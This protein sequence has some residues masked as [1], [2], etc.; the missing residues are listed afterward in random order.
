MSVSSIGAQS[1]LIMQQLV[2]MRSQFDDLQRQLGTG[3]KSATYAGLGINRGV[4]VS[5]NA[6]LSA[7][8]GYDNTIDNVMARIN[9]MNT[10]LGNMIDI[11]TTVKSAMVQANGVSN[12]SGALVAQQTG[13]SS[14]DQLLALLNA[15]AGDRYLFSGR[16]T[17]TPAVETLDHIMNGDGARAGLKQLIFERNQADLGI[18]GLGRLTIGG[19]GNSVQVDEQTTS[20][21]L[22]L[23][24]ITSTVTG[25]TVSGPTGS[26]A[27]ESIDFSAAAPNPGETVTLRFNLPD[28]TSENL[29]LT[30][31]TDSPPGSNEFTIGT[32]PG[33]TASSF[34]TALSTAVGKL[35]GTSLTAASAIAAS[36]DFFNADANNPPQ[37]VGGSSPFYAATGM[38][39]G[40][41]A[42]TVIWYTG[43][44]GT[45]PARS[46]ATAKI[47][48]SLSV[49]Y[50]A[51][52]NEDALR[53]LVQN[54]ATL[55]AV[56]ISPTDP[57]G[58]GLSS[59][60]DQRLTAN[61]GAPGTQTVTDIES[62][63]ASAQTSL[64]AAK[65]RHQQANSTLNDFL[66]QIE[67]VSNEDVG[68]QLL[69]LQTRMQAS[70]QVTSMLSQLSLVNFL[71]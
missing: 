24:S 50:G 16:A 52:A 40:T 27:S 68:A 29:T 66:Q 14:L 59:E 56:T 64:K 5:L 3:Q 43:E 67:G 63:L 60:L 25:A 39:A 38:V 58:V 44:T 22:K 71:K 26:P 20:F 70:M 54:V 69:T 62:D 8:S 23:A 45:D 65:D 33:Q 9:L 21:G 30:A 10:A 7:I 17:N 51:R 53:T 37:R 6:Q 42:N 2:Q 11:T 55:A 19:S 12:G 13:Q 47:D 48:Q 57:N 15:Q 36:S 49:S 1:A 61:L 35:A 18:D 46:T 34:Q 31:T 41:A 28:G 4:T 32:T